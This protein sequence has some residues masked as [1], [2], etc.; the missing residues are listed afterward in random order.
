MGWSAAPLVLPA[1][2]QR[3]VEHTIAGLYQPAGREREDFSQPAGEAALIAPDS[4][5]W[6]VFKNPAVLFIGGVAA[7][8]LELAEPRVRT[9]V[10]EHSAFREQPLERL[11]RT[12]L[13]TVV[14]VYGARSRAEAMIERV[15]RLH[16][17]IA[18]TTPCGDRYAATDPQLLTWV[19]ATAAFGFLEAYHAFVRPLDGEERDRFYAEGLAAAQLYGASGAPGSQ[20]EQSALFEHMRARLEASDI[21]HEFLAIVRRMPAL[22]APLRP[23]QSLLVRAAIDVVPAWA[24]ERLGLPRMPLTAWQRGLVCR[25]AAGADRLL[26]RS[27]AAVQ[28]CR[29]LALQDDYLYAAAPWA[30]LDAPR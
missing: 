6:M 2:L 15:T 20:A 24:R 18:G 14:T 11:R 13:A 25:I 5:S 19:Q 3:R 28:S 21:V 17:R 1:A 29:R 22:A 23:M 12:A 27:S 26:L 4:V 30:A 16:G 7:V 9:G 8:V 10:W